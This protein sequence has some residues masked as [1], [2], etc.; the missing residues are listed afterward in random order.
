MELKGNDF[1]KISI[2][3]VFCWTKFGS[4]AGESADMILQRK[5]VERNLN[6]GIFLWGIGQSIRPSL[7]SLLRLTD[8]PKI[9][10]S[11]MKSAPALQ[12]ASPSSIVVWHE[13]IGFD[14][15]PY[16][17]PEHSVVTS[18]YDAKL[19]RAHHYALVCKR[20]Q[21]I[22]FQQENVPRLPVGSLRNLIS[23]AQIGS[24]Q[25]TSVVRYVQNRDTG[26]ADYHVA[27][28]AQLVPP[29]LIRLFRGVV[30]PRIHP[31]DDASSRRRTLAAR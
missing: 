17:L 27:I 29:Y 5:E 2:P 23:G 4:E 24:S 7:L 31:A 12:D 22:A 9:L 6:Q 13:G 20:S 10:F 11:P 26:G 19:P 8:T 30:V 25:V 21:P 3:E 18:R 15:R 16:T 1:V 28:E 14:G